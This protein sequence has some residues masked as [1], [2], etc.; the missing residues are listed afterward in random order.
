MDENEKETLALFIAFLAV[1]IAFTEDSSREQIRNTL[2]LLLSDF[3]LPPFS[4][5][6]K[7]SFFSYS[8]PDNQQSDSYS[9]DGRQI[10]FWIMNDTNLPPP[11]SKEPIDLG[12]MEFALDDDF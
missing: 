8:K 2:W 9:I 3:S 5:K 1:F 12:P 10:D 6:N 7:H 4:H 11:A